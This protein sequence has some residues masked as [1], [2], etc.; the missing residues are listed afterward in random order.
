M[1]VRAHELS[2]KAKSVNRC[3]VDTGDNSPERIIVVHVSQCLWIVIL[4]MN[5]Y[6]PVPI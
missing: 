1:R 3:A 5:D 2:R 6:D 4:S